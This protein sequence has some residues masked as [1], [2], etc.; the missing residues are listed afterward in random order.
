MSMSINPFGLLE[1]EQDDRLSRVLFD[2]AR[3]GMWP[4]RG[5]KIEIGLEYEIDFNRDRIWVEVYGTGWG[6]FASV[7]VDH[8]D[9]LDIPEITV[10]KIAQEIVQLLRNR[11]DYRLAPLIYLGE[12]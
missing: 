10:H 3:E 6:F 12:N 4:F 5:D 1:V 11:E 8:Y 7:L 2:A 9:M